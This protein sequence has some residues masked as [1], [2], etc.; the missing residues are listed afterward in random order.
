LKGERKEKKTKCGSF[1][2]PK[3]FICTR[4]RS[5]CFMGRVISDQ[6]IQK[7]A[8]MSAWFRGTKSSDPVCGAPPEGVSG[9]EQSVENQIWR[10]QLDLA[11]GGVRSLLLRCPDG[12][13]ELA[14]PEAAIHP[15]QGILRD[16]AGRLA[17]ASQF[18]QSR[19]RFDDTG[20]ALAVESS[21]AGGVWQTTFRVKTGDPALVVEAG[22][23]GLAP[24]SS[25]EMALP[26]MMPGV[27]VT[28]LGPA[29]RPEQGTAILSGDAGRA[30]MTLRA[31]ERFRSGCYAWK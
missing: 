28:G 27:T 8:G 19:L 25:L 23:P 21:L 4:L 18:V 12:A 9:S 30:Q 26:R 17:A 16:P 15:F 14:D 24:G 29:W 31:D 6:A 5:K 20:A 1:D 22:W 2:F 10:I 3:P 13:R 7:E 11:T